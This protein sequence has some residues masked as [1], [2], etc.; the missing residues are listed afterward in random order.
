MAPRFT[1]CELRSLSPFEN[2]KSQILAS[3]LKVKITQQFI[4]QLF[5]EIPLCLLYITEPELQ[6]H[7]HS[8]CATNL[9]FATARFSVHIYHKFLNIVFTF[10]DFRNLT[11][12]QL[13]TMAPPSVHNTNFQSLQWPQL[14][15]YSQ[16]TKNTTI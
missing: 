16:L 10:T 11:E 2:W 4:T 7:S 9:S 14:S 3:S 6:A 1:Q 5:P 15:F 8:P 13:Y 12:I